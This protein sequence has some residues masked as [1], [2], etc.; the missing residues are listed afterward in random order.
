MNDQPIS[1]RTLALYR[2]YLDELVGMLIA[3]DE[4]IANA[5]AVL[6]PLSETLTAFQQKLDNIERKDQP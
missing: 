6:H 3:M 4:D 2:Q 1:S 5:L